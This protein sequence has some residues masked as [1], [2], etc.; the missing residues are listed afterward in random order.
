MK[1]DSKEKI[2]QFLA[3][4]L[5]MTLVW[6]YGSALEGTEFSGGRL[7]GP[8]LDMKDIGT[9]LLILAVILTFFYRR[10]GAAIALLGSLLCLPLYLYFLAPYPFR[11]VFRGDYSVAAPS[12]FVWSNWGIAGVFALA[13]TA[14]FSVRSLARPAASRASQ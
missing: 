9:L 7:T 3:Y 11:W 4:L 10:I 5:C 14:G 1:R 2:G 8:L 6:R 13:L 12:N